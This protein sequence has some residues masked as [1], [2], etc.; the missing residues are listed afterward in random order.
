LTLLGVVTALKAEAMVLVK[1]PM[2]V[3]EVLHLPE[4]KLVKLS[5]I[6]PKQARLA[7]EAL[8]ENGA[9]ALLSWGIAG[10]I[11]A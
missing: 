7:S 6:G 3:G 11:H 4:G 8:V 2:A 10:G 5:G 9:T 1:R